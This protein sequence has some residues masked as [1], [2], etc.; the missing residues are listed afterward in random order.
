MS[1]GL[2]ISA[3]GTLDTTLLTGPRIPYALARA[4]MLPAGLSRISAHGVPA[5]AIIS[6]GVWSTVLSVSGT[7]DIL[8][9]IYIFIL[10]VFFGLSG[11]CSFRTASS[12]S[13]V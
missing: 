9:D 11:I 4:G 8:T 2:M 7:F 10:W 13:K 3:Y 6:V 12:G 5:V 1:V